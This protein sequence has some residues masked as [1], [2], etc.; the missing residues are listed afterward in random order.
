M[1]IKR[2]IVGIDGPE[3][4]DKAL[5]AAQYLP[6]DELATPAYRALTLGRPQW[7]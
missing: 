1:P 4:L 3:A 7:L 6:G 2:K 5:R